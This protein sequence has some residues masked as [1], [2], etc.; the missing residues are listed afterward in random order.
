MDHDQHD[1][2]LV[3]SHGW[4]TEP[5]PSVGMLLRPAND[6]RLPDNLVARATAAR[7]DEDHDDGL[8]HGHGWASSEDRARA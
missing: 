4:A 5:P 8:V 1:D 7:Q 2:G 6:D 3:H